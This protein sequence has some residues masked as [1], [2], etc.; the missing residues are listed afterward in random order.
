MG[1]LAEWL[2]R[3]ELDPF[4][5]YARS[6]INEKYTL[7]DKFGLGKG[8]FVKELGARGVYLSYSYPV[9]RYGYDRY[10]F[11]PCPLSLH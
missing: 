5:T 1:F 6:M 2:E 11:L 9:T 10:C 8:E 4:I 3:K 7:F